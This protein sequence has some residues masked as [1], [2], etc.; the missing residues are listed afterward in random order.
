MD[1]KD[2]DGLVGGALLQ[3]ARIAR[4]LSRKEVSDALGISQKVIRRCEAGEAE[5]NGYRPKDRTA[6]TIADFYEVDVFR[7]FPHLEHPS[8]RSNT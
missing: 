2:S 1:S 8:T 4:R 6:F 5:R 7:A 3:H